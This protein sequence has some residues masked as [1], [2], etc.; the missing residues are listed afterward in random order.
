MPE[1]RRVKVLPFEGEELE[2]VGRAMQFRSPMPWEG[3]EQQASPY[4]WWLQY[5]KRNT[6]YVECCEKGGNGLAAEFYADWGDV[7]N[8]T[9]GEKIHDWLEECGCDLFVEPGVST[10]ANEADYK[11]VDHSRFMV[12]AYP[13]KVDGTAMTPQAIRQ[14]L[15]IFLDEQFGK[16]PNRAP[17]YW[18]AARYRIHGRPDP[19]KLK[20]QLAVYDLKNAEP[21]LELWQIGERLLQEGTL[22]IGESHRTDGVHAKGLFPAE[23]ADRRKMMTTTVRRYF[24]SAK[25]IISNSTGKVFPIE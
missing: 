17:D 13:V 6:A 16:L 15:E 8:L 14:Q 24:E 9:D 3:D 20:E 7:R 11:A 2:A 1:L 25:A 21:N 12:I 10:I 19:R 23:I 18:S 22:S 5:V 4:Y